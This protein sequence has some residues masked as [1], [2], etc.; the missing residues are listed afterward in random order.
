MAPKEDLNL[1]R[2]MKLR[3]EV[4][5]DSPGDY[6]KVRVTGNAEG[7]YNL[8]FLE[9]YFEISGSEILKVQVV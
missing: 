1:G 3:R 5:P 8:K 2:L 7:A 6:E 9:S 4:F